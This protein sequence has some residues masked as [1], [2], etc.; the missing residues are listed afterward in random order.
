VDQLG[1]K[2]LSSLMVLPQEGDD[3]VWQD[4][5]AAQ[6]GERKRDGGPRAEGKRGRREGKLSKT[7]FIDLFETT[8]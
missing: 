1:R 2:G 8:Q 7:A 3:L 5:E 4:P 6:E